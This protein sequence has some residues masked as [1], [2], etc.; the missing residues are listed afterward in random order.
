M[1]IAAMSEL[2]QG[3]P[4]AHRVEHSFYS[5][6]QRLRVRACALRRIA[7]IFEQ[8]CSCCAHRYR[9]SS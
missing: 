9:A 5:P 7:F 6:N 8:A 1:R 2:A 3:V 4:P